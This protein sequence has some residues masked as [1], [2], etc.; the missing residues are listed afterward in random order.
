MQEDAAW[1]RNAL[2]M[3]L[4]ASAAGAKAVS[5]SDFLPK[6][7]RGEMPKLAGE[8]LLSALRGAFGLQ[9]KGNK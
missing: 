8:E 5:P 6:S 1:E 9:K 7:M 4:V 2:L 3:T